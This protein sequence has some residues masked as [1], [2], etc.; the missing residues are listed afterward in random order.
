MGQRHQTFIIARIIPHGQTAAKYRCIG[1][2]HSQWCYG[3]LPL[4]ATL[5]F[6]TLI[7]QP[8]NAEIIRYEISETNG[9]YGRWGE[10]PRLVDVPCPYSLFLLG[11]AW[12]VDLDPSNYYAAGVN[13][14]HG[15][16]SARMR[17]FGGG[18][19]LFLAI[20]ICPSL[21]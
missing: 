13:F 20:N 3:T 11:S 18:E 9:K 15:I 7:K 17:S 16:L 4:K 2:F 5:R 12:N 10:K 6:L 14:L 21:I 1:A 8:A 19:F